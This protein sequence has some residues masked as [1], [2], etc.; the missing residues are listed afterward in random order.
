MAISEREFRGSWHDLHLLIDDYFT[1]YN[2]YIFRGQADAS[3]PL[4]STLARTI[5]Q[6]YPTA[7]QNQTS[8]L[9]SEH[10]RSFKRNVRG[11]C[12]LDLEAASHDTLWS[13]GQHFGL[14]TPFLD[15]SRSPY[16]ALFLP[17][18]ELLIAVVRHFGQFMKVISKTFFPSSHRSYTSEFVE[19]LGHEN[20]RLV[21][22]NGLFLDI[23]VGMEANKLIEDAD[24]LEWVTM[25]KIEFP[26]ELRPDIQ[27]ALNNMNINHASLFPDISGAALFTNYQLESEPMLAIG[28]VKGFKGEER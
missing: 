5:R 8:E 23:P 14:S 13:L 9:V 24:A 1:H 28:R 3:W 10:I 27:S 18:S 16:V 22:Q 2:S 26:S 19:P 17:F 6:H 20:S 7:T 11:R 25:I 4:V 12:T 15:W 21:H